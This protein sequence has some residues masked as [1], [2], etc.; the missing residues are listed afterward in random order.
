MSLKSHIHLGLGII[1][2]NLNSD[3]PRNR[4]CTNPKPPIPVHPLTNVHHCIDLYALGGFFLG[5][6]DCSFDTLNLIS[7]GMNFT[8]PEQAYLVCGNVAYSCVPDIGDYY[9]R[10]VIGKCYL[11]YLVPLIRQT[12]DRELAPFHVRHK[13]TISLGSRILSVLIPSYGTY[14]S[15]EEIVTL[16]KVLERHMNTTSIA[17]SAVQKEVND[18][19]QVAL[20]NRMALDLV[21]AAQG[22]VCK[23][24]NTECCTYISDATS[25]VHDVIADTEQGIKELHEDHGWN[26]FGGMQ[27]WVGSWG[28]SLLK[29]LIWIIG[30]IILV[31]IVITLITTISKICVGRIVTTY[32]SGQHTSIPMEHPVQK[33]T[34]PY[35]DSDDSDELEDCV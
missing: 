35:L 18:I 20:Q 14:R 32:A 8:L 23:V 2:L 10:S 22:G 26:P 12:D 25:A 30:G 1:V 29:G 9:K 21:L 34:P 13:P 11:A 27:A 7:D 15:Q 3:R 24:I 31:I 33:W 4:D 16:S 28:A 19:R 6:C 5:T 17:L